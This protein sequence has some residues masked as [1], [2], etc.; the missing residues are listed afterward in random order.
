M[1]RFTADL[2]NSGT[3]YGFGLTETNLN[4]MQF[5]QEPIF[6]SF[7][8]AGSPGLFGLILYMGQFNKP[9]DIKQNP[10]VVEEACTPFLLPERGVTFNSLR[11][12]P[13]AQSVMEEF[14]EKPFWSHQT[15]I[16]IGSKNDVQLFFAGPDEKSM[17][18]FFQNAGLLSSKT[19]RM[20]K[21]FG[22][23]GDRNG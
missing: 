6:F 10:L 15:R 21:G 16:E 4:R 2:Q 1:I 11:V 14:R 22:K 17:S 5:N 18:Q 3:L 7:E 9:E 8:Y 20:N 13:I 19:K 23:G 12:F